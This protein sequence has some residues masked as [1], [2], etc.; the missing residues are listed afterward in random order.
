MAQVFK[1][2][3]CDKYSKGDFWSAHT[4]NVSCAPATN[5]TPSK[6]YELCRS[7]AGDLE[8]FLDRP[9]LAELAPSA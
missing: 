4:T 8:R 6:D 5:S 1:C 2:D 3:R 9:D 7:C